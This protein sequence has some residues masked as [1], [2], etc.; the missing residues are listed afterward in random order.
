MTK[1]RQSCQILRQIE[2]LKGRATT[3]LL[4][5]LLPEIDM[6]SISSAIGNMLKQ[7][8]VQKNGRVESSRAF[9]Y[10]VNSD[11]EPGLARKPRKKGGYVPTPPSPATV[12]QGSA[13][14]MIVIRYREAKVKMLCRLLSAGVL[15]GNERDLMIGL[16]ADLG[17]RAGT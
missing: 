17:H 5:E 10:Q 12:R 1:M 13:S 2:S 3:K 7:D 6:T 9:F 8:R 4:A 16:L 15:N 14:N 11:W